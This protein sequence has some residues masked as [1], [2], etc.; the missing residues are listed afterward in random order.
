MFQKYQLKRTFALSER[1]LAVR[2]HG[3]R[4]SSRALDFRHAFREQTLDIEVVRKNNLPDLVSPYVHVLH[5]LRVSMG[6]DEFDVFQQKVHQ[7]RA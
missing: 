4:P 5:E 6:L 3:S 1:F 7:R 2:H